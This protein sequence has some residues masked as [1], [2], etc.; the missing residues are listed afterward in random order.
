VSQQPHVEAFL[1]LLGDLRKFVTTSPNS[2]APPYVV[3]HPSMPWKQP[4]SE[5]LC[6]QRSRSDNEIQTTC[7]GLT[8]EQAH[9][10][11]GLIRERVEEKRPVIT[12][13]QTGLIR[14]EFTQPARRD[15]D[16][17][18]PVFYAVDG[19]SFTSTPA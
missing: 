8:T 3:V 16:V 7:V 11:A 9:F 15:G 18:P 19:W 12:G 4:D 1:T 10:Y 2:T 6:G 14:N 13:Q 5:A 17:T